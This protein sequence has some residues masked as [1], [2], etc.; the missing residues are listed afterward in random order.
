MLLSGSHV[1]FLPFLLPASDICEA[2]CEWLKEIFT[3]GDVLYST[4][5]LTFLL[6]HHQ[7]TDGY[8]F[9]LFKVFGERNFTISHGNLS[10]RTASDFLKNDMENCLH[11][12]FLF[13]LR[14]FF[15][16]ENKIGCLK[17]HMNNEPSSSLFPE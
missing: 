10:S 6:L 4:A 3:K 13:F 15:T 12:S 5:F 9:C 16:P 14:V 7:G 11:Y 1:P 2:G 8:L 17:M